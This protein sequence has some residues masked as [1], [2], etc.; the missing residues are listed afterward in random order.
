MKILITT[1]HLV[2][3]SG[4]EL[5]TYDTAKGMK[6]RGHQV[7]VHSAFLG[8]IAEE[9][10]KLDV[11]VANS[12]DD[13]SENQFDIIHAHHN[14]TSILARAKFPETPLVMW[15][16][17]IL[18]FLEQPPSIDINIQAYIAISEEVSKNLVKKG[19]DPSIIKIL[20]NAAD[21]ERFF[22]RSEINESL[23]NVLV[24]CHYHVNDELLKVIK[25]VCS[26]LGVNLVVVGDK[27]RQIWSMED[28]INNVDL[29]I[30]TGRGI[31]EAMSCG[32][33]ALVLNM[34]R[35]AWF[36][37]G[38]I[39][40]DNY[41]Q[42]IKTSFSGRVF[43]HEFGADFLRD[44]LLK[45]DKNMGKTNRQIVLESMTLDDKL[46]QL[47][48]IYEEAQKDFKPRSINVPVD[49]IIHYQHVLTGTFED[50]FQMEKMESELEN[51][52]TIVNYVLN[53]KSWKLTSPLRFIRRLFNS[54]QD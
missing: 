14:I 19:V 27:K 4:T 38:I 45:Y 34:Y 39:N 46:D 35:D 37:D 31:I 51:Y 17:G 43:N 44:Q 7:F 3:Y 8:R 47:E 26:Q 9:I 10:R 48:L 42:M 21:Q 15:A 18:P 28:T 22:P 24:I 52:E 30:T 5:V 53:S 25:D 6:K 23:K 12:L 54:S 50:N 13:F 33:A 20:M 40:K 16:H 11:P 2:N 49:E 36:G 41:K 29:V 32:R 1:H